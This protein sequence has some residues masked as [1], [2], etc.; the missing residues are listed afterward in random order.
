M[1]S[2][3][4]PQAP[5]RPTACTRSSPPRSSNGAIPA[6][7]ARPACWSSRSRYDR[8]GERAKKKAASL[9]HVPYSS[10]D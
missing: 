10:D 8:R 7:S 1:R 5:K 2:V 3:T 6:S 4:V 9:L